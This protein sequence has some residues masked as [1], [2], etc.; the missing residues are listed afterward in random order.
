MTVDKKIKTISRLHLGLLLGL[1]ERT[2]PDMY[3]EKNGFAV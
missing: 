3:C 1:C 2:K